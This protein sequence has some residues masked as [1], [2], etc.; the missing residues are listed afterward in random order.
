MSQAWL[1]ALPGPL[2]E[3]PAPEFTQ[4]MAWMLMVP[5]PACEPHV[6]INICGKN[7][8]EFGEVLMCAKLPFDTWRIRHDSV[9]M[10]IQSLGIESGLIVDT[11]PFG[12]FSHLIPASAYSENGHLFHHRERQGLVPDFLVTSPPDHGQQSSF[13]CELKMISAGLTYYQSRS[14]DRSVEIRAKQLPKL[15]RDKA[16][17]IDKTY[18]RVQPNQKGP[19]ERRLEQF[20]DI[21]CFVIGQ[22]S[23]ASPDLHS[24]ISKCASSKSK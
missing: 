22:F 12:L 15:Y 2:S 3:I 24:F 4:A 9:K 13:L 20:G 19:V 6:G 1:S 7:L 14:G 10:M 16:K 18:C 21:S 11:E 5:S 17:N 8:D 23:E